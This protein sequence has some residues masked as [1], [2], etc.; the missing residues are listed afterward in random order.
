MMYLTR[1]TK[2]N[3]RGG[4]KPTGFYITVFRDHTGQRRRM[5]TQITNK[6]AADSFKN[7]LKRVVEFKI[8]GDHP[9]PEILQWI[10]TLPPQ[11][12]DR[13]IEYNLI[14][15][16]RVANTMPLIKHLEDY[17]KTKLA[18]GVTGRHADLEK[19]RVKRVLNATK[20][21]YWSDS[22]QLFNKS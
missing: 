6:P 21:K 1:N 5:S 13:L 15:R 16:K 8:A 12:K 10:E 7:K 11:I 14:D 3:A 20:F 17:H 19:D 2:P 9:G 22:R 4:R 18:S